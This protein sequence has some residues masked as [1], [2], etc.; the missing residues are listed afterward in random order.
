MGSCRSLPRGVVVFRAPGFEPLPFVRQRM[1]LF[2]ASVELKM[3]SFLLIAPFLVA[4]LQECLALSQGIRGVFVCLAMLFLSSSL[5]CGLCFAAVYRY[6]FLFFLS[7]LRV[8]PRFFCAVA[9]VR[10]VPR[11]L[12]FVLLFV[13][14]CTSSCCPVD[15]FFRVPGPAFV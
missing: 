13:V 5:S 8:F 7:R 9:V 1:G 12:L 3:A 10:H 4:C 11:L 2:L 6:L 14:S 15:V